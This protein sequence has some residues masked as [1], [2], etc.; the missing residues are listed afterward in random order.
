MAER[1]AGRMMTTRL[2]KEAGSHEEGPSNL[3]E[4]GTT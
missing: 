1:L 4:Q 3:R 2:G